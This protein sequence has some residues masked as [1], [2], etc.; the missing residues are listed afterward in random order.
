MK[1]SD[2]QQDMCCALEVGSK[3]STVR[4]DFSCVW[5]LN[6]RDKG[7]TFLVF[8]NPLDL[9]WYIY[10]PQQVFQRLDFFHTQSCSHTPEAQHQVQEAAHTG[11]KEAVEALLCDRQA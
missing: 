3:K 5:V 11:D 8:F 9:G 7:S 10:S 1:A 4:L 2:S 6:L